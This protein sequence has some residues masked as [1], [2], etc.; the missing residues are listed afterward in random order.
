MCRLTKI[1]LVDIKNVNKFFVLQLL[2][3]WFHIPSSHCNK[4]ALQ[5]RSHLNLWWKSYAPDK[6][7]SKKINQRGFIQ[8]RNKVEIWFLSTA[9]RV[10]VR[11]MH[12]KYGV[13]QTYGNN[14]M[15]WTR[16]VF[17]NQLKGN[18]SKTKQG[19][20]TF[21]VHWTSSHCQK[22]AYQVWSH[23][24]LWWQSYAPDKKCDIKSI[25]GE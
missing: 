17:L 13:L 11:N 9:L 20:V 19:R 22:H 23:S 7:F 14:V 5:V 3:M 21:L 4:H 8:R 6:K 18:N 12:T 10:I 24:N 1:I 25:K 2:A 15:L 16:N